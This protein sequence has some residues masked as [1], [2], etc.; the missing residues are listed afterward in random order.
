[1]LLIARIVRLAGSAAIAFL[2]AGIGI[3]V[4][5][6]STQSEVLGFIEKT[7]SALASPFEDIFLPDDAKLRIALNW[8]FA[9]AVYGIAAW[10]IAYLLWRAHTGV[11]M[12]RRARGA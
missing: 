2:V 1:M 12:C 4:F 8:G 3:H 11:G 5:E 6:I 10:N 7:A 9:A